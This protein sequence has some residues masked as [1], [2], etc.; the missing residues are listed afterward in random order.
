[1]LSDAEVLD[2]VH[3]QLPIHSVEIVTI[4]RLHCLGQCKSEAVVGSYLGPG[5]Y[6]RSSLCCAVGDRS[7]PVFLDCV[8]GGLGIDS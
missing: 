7:L 5:H 2:T 6:G 8:Y 1:M 3:P 4:V